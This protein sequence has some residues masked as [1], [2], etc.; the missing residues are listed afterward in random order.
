M[1]RRRYY[2]SVHSK[3]IME[4][5]GDGAYEFEVEAT[6]EELDEL[7]DLFADLEIDENKTAFRGALQPAKPY[8]LDGENDA[9]DD[10]LNEIYNLLL[11]IGT[12]ETVRHLN[13]MRLY[14]APELESEAPRETL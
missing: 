6:P 14:P 13:G 4:N 5:Q 10:D 3:S 9:Y 2:V 11:R 7:R 1:D 12:E 8:H